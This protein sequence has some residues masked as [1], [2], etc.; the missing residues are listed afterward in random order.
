MQRIYQVIRQVAGTPTAV[1]ITGES[2]TGKASDR[3]VAGRA[4]AGD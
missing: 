3:A 2:G 4:V 1:L